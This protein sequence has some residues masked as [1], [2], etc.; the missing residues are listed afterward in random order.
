M[1]TIYLAARIATLGGNNFAT[2]GFA[3][4]LLGVRDC[5]GVSVNTLARMAK[6]F[7]MHNR[8]AI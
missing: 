4:M 1:G 2:T 6:V 5:S 3:L 8:K 7:I